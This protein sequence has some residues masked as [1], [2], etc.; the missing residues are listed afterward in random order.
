LT[1]QTPSLPDQNCFAPSWL[2]I[3][4]KQLHKNLATLKGKT[5][6]NVQFVAVVK[7][8][9]YGHGAIPIS[10]SLEAHV[11]KL[12]VAHINEAVELRDAGIEAPIIVLAPPE[13]SFTQLYRRYEL[14][15][16][17]SELKQFNDLAPGTY[18]H[19]QFDTGMKRLGIDPRDIEEAVDK[20][21]HFRELHLTGLMSHFATADEP[22]SEKVDNQN[23]LFKEISAHFRDWDV[24]FHIANS[25]ALAF[26]PET[27]Q[28]MVR[29]GISLYGYQPDTTPISGIAPI[30]TWNSYIV[31]ARPIKK[32]ETV[33]YGATWTA[34]KDGYILTIPAGYADG[35]PRIL[36]NSIEVWVGGHSL[37]QVGTITMDYIMVFSQSPFET[38]TR[39]TLLS[40]EG[41]TASDWAK[42][43]RTI[44]YE[45]V[46]KIGS[47]VERRYHS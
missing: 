10:R 22:G 37:P 34:P 26:Y 16:V 20:V 46:A 6:G 36:S 18:Y 21:N 3:N 44:S 1:R 9:A 41:P 4:L 42:A 45:I 23:A 25:G 43:S 5:S 12:A 30:L 13:P 8:N 7:A 11:D 2:D 47:R 17:I 31:Q 14:E 28:S 33:S 27:H 40:P 29:L 39:V 35:I 38:G 19:L 32:D 24:S 15:A